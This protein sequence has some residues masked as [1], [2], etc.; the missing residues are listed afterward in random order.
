[1]ISRAIV[2]A[3]VVTGVGLVLT[4][5]RLG[6]LVVAMLGGFVWWLIPGYLIVWAAPSSRSG[7]PS[8]CAAC[9]RVANGITYVDSGWAQPVPLSL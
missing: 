5:F 8:T 2:L 3:A 6:P 7:P 9:I 4:L 1:M